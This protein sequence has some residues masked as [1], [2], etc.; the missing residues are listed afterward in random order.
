MPII[1]AAIA[2]IEQVGLWGVFTTRSFRGI[3]S[4]PLRM[5]KISFEIYTIG[6]QSVSIILFTGFF[7]GMVLGLQG[8]HT[9][10]R[11][12]ADGFLGSLIA[13]SLLAELAPVLTALLVIGRAGST[14]CAEIGVMRISEQIEALE[15]LAIDVYNYL[16]SPKLVAAMIAM[17]L[18]VFIFSVSGMIGGYFSGCVI[19]GVNRGDYYQSMVSVVDFETLRMT[20]TKGF[21]F[22]ILVVMIS[23]FRGFYLH[24]QRD[25]GALAL[26]RTTTYAVVLSSVGVLILDYLLTAVLI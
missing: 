5:N 3:A 23:A 25:R 1:K 15:C 26:S 6:W 22:A 20:L 13:K 10:K 16:I 11:F 21:L 19:L 14:M 24:T 12:G 4:K 8:Y 17:P 7:T 2:T 18:L 9:L